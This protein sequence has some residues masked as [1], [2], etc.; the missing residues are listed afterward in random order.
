M[1]ILINRDSIIFPFTPGKSMSNINLYF[2]KIREEKGRER[3]R[4]NYE[5]FKTK[6]RNNKLLNVI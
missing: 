2:S 5:L 1:Y 6:E 4:W 3:R